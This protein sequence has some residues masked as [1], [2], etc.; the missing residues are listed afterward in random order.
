MLQDYVIFFETDS[1]E[2]EKVDTVKY[3]HSVLGEKINVASRSQDDEILF[4]SS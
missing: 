4:H 3:F 2:G 1:R